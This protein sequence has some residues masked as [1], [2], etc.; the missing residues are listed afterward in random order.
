MENPKARMRHSYLI[1]GLPKHER[2]TVSYCKYGF[3]YQKDTD[4]WTNAEDRMPI[5]K[6]CKEFQCDFLKTTGR[7]THKAG[8]RD[9]SSQHSKESQKYQEAGTKTLLDRYK[10]P[11]DLIEEMLSACVE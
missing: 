4:I 5:P 9:R 8:I 10:I 7:T 2:Q 3:D 6:C 1:S 11:P